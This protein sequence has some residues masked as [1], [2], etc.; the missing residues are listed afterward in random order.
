M[1]IILNSI[2]IGEILLMQFVMEKLLLLREISN[3]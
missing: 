2:K 3:G 1:N